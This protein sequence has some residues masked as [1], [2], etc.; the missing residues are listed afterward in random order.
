MRLLTTTLATLTVV[1]LV[2]CG[3][4]SGSGTT[5]VGNVSPTAGT[6]RIYVTDAPFPYDYVQSATVE[7]EEIR[8]RNASA[9]EDEGWVTV[10]TGPAMVDL[11]PL[12]GGAVLPLVEADLEA[13]T[14][15][16]VRV[17]VSAGEVTLKPEAFAENDDRV[18]NT[19]ND[20]LKFPS[21]AQSGLKV[22]I[23]NG[24]EVVT[25]LS[26]DLTLDFDLSKNFVFN[27]PISHPPGVKGVLFTPVVRAT[28]NS[29]TGS[30]QVTVYSDGLIPGTQDGGLLTTASIKV[31]PAGSVDT[32]PEGFPVEA[33][34][35]DA[36]VAA[37]M[38][39]EPGTYDVVVEA[40]GHTSQTVENL[41]V[42]VA[43]LTTQEV[44]LAASGEI[45]GTVMSDNAT[46]GD[47]TDDFSLFEVAVDAVPTAGGPSA[48]DDSS[49]ESGGWAITNLDPGSYDLTFTKAGFTDGAL[50]GVVAE[51][52]SP[53]FLVVMTSLTRDLDGTVSDTAGTVGG[54]TL[55]LKTKA[56]DTVA[57]TTSDATNGTWALPGV[58]TR[59][60]DLVIE[61][62]DGAGT[63]RSKTVE[64]GVEG[65]AGSTALT[66]DV[67]L[68]A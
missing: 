47:P 1:A 50:N 3:G 40:G 46:P 23:E 18:Y 54:A 62:D 22:K 12:T 16:Q 41:A 55:T 8:V 25:Q 28:N 52:D 42:A 61:H 36:G 57:T 11:V 67:D 20:R 49:N 35:S 66:R 39:L 37:V 13:G 31:Y 38:G 63:V 43:N 19:A 21:A 10:Y 53:G 34:A 60:Y 15:D 29:T 59:K 30:L 24:I 58:P 33:G 14:Y 2:A 6:L 17:I 5:D 9:A 4:G 64:V 65:D 56:G 45:D 32:P 7:I 48:G 27:G 44:T 68:D 51:V 26:S